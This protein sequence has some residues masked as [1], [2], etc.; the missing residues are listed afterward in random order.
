MF[1]FYKNIFYKWCT[2][3]L[4]SNMF[5]LMHEHSPPLS[6]SRA[7]MGDLHYSWLEIIIFTPLTQWVQHFFSKLHISLVCL[8]HQN[9]TIQLHH[10]LQVTDSRL[11]GK[12]WEATPSFL[13]SLINFGQWVWSWP[14]KIHQQPNLQEQERFLPNSSP[15]SI[16][17]RIQFT[18]AGCNEFNW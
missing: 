8:S 6:P 12:D 3:L 18:V 9:F 2:H 4:R 1:I 7:T 5:S 17:V 10:D 14:L 11:W 16:F 13:N 15:I